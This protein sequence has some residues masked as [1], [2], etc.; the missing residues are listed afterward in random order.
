MIDKVIH[1]SI[2][3]RILKKH[4]R[5]H[6][7]A[8]GNPDL[9]HCHI[10]LN[11]GWLGLWAKRKY[12]IPYLV[13]EH[14]SGYMPEAINGFAAYNPWSKRLFSKILSGAE[15]VTG[16]SQALIQVLQKLH[17][18]ATYVRLPNVV[19]EMIFTP[20]TI[21]TS[22]GIFKVIHISTFSAH[23]NMDDTFTA[24]DALAADHKSIEFH[25]VGPQDKIANK[26]PHRKFST[27]YNFHGEMPQQ[28]LAQLIQSCDVC[29]LYSHYETFGC[30]IIEANAVGVPV[31]VSDI[32][33]LQEIVQS[34]K[35]GILVPP[36]NPKALY[37]VLAAV[38]NKEHHFRASEISK[39]TFEKFTYKVVGAQ[40]FT[41]YNAVFP[42][43][44]LS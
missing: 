3:Y 23:K 40:I 5:Q 32:P 25:I 10:I 44:I 28:N 15:L 33:V 37:Q 19:D 39:T 13:T 34:N 35:N 8:Y 12:K 14:W 18:Q 11:T 42:G 36:S 7:E 24:F 17:P 27:A 31:V 20:P 1:W 41:L 21:K 6:F 43:K 29:V 2:W 38:M 9:L 30:V 4:L 26:W 16:V 22:G